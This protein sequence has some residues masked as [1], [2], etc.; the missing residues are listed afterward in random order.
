M[1]RL[2][3]VLCACQA[4]SPHTPSSGDPR[5]QGEIVLVV[6]APGVELGLGLIGSLHSDS[7]DCH[8]E[9]WICCQFMS[10]P[11]ISF[12]RSGPKEEYSQLNQLLEDISSYMRDLNAIRATQAQ[13]RAAQAKK[14][15]DD[16]RKV[17]EMRQAAMEVL[18]SKFADFL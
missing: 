4:L 13:E 5:S 11:T 7:Y 16:K 15:E 6:A 8:S 9:L 14:S 18:L 1:P 12:C 3:K 10:T 2:W 17:E